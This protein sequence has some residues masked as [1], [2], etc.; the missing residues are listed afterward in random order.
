MQQ[1]T[2][3]QLPLK[4]YPGKPSLHEL[5]ASLLHQQV[6][7]SRAVAQLEPGCQQPTG[8]EARCSSDGCP[9]GSP[10]LCCSPP[11]SQGTCQTL[12]NAGSQALSRK[13]GI[14]SRDTNCLLA[15]SQRQGPQAMADG[16]VMQHW[17]LGL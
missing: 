3:E 1:R 12:Q 8:V 17:A 15:S 13:Q 4:A 14:C 9:L 16:T 7:L 11:C 5:G 10:V 2:D 6:E